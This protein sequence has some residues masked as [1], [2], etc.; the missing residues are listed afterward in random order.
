MGNYIDIKKNCCCH[1]K[2][3]KKPVKHPISYFDDTNSQNDVY[4]DHC[5]HICHTYFECYGQCDIND[6]NDKNNIKKCECKSCSC[7]PCECKC[8]KIN[9]WK[10]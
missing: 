10:M 1:K 9:I 3:C 4:C 7:T 5:G 2:N 6:I 8:N